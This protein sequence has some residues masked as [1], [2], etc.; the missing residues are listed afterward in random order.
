MGLS[1][2]D[3][4]QVDLGVLADAADDWKRTV[5][6]LKAL[7][8]QARKGLKAKADAARWAGVNASVSREFVGMTVKEI[9]DLYGEARGVHRALSDAH[10]DLS[11]CQTRMRAAVDEATRLGLIVAEGSGGRARCRF[12]AAPDAADAPGVAARPETSREAR[13]KALEAEIN[14]I[15]DVAAELDE[16]VAATLARIHGGDPHDADGR[17]VTVDQV[18]VERAA[19]LVAHARALAGRGETLSEARLRELDLI[20]EGNVGDAEFATGFYRS[21]GK[22]EAVLEFYG[23]MSLD[24]TEGH[25]AS[26]LALTRRLQEGMGLALAT[27]TDPDSRVRLPAGWGEEFR[28]LGTQPVAVNPLGPVQPLGYQVLGGLLRH[29]EYDPRFLLPI[30]E[31]VAQLHHRSP[32]LF[33]LATPGALGEDSDLGFNPGGGTGNGYDPLAS[34]LEGLGHSPEAAKQFFSDATPTV[35]RD[36]GSVE[37]TGKLGYSYFDELTRA[38]FDWP[39]ESSASPGSEKGIAAASHGPDALGHALEAAVT[40]APWDSAHGGLPRDPESVE[41]MRKVMDRYN[42]TRETP[43]PDAMM[44]SLGRMGAA[45]IDEFNYGSYGVGGGDHAN[46]EVIFA[47][48][49]RLG[50]EP[51]FGETDIANF[52]MLAGG[53]EE[54][55]GTLKS[56]QSL[57]VASGLAALENDHGRGS[58]FAQNTAELHGMLDES[59]AHAVRQEFRD[60]EDEKNLAG[61][62]AAEWRK[63]GVN[64]G[65]GVVVGAGVALIAGP[66]AGVVTAVA[67][68]IFVESV[69]STVNTAY[70]THTLEYL[71]ASEFNNDG[72]A[73]IEAGAVTE[74]GEKSAVR[75]T[76]RYAM[77]SGMGYEQVGQLNQ[78]VGRSYHQGRGTIKDRELAQ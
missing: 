29:G 64:A 73:I 63:N 22:P 17:Y 7:R 69:G 9:G 20:L 10:A 1:F 46:R 40:G 56:A 3:L 37:P 21:F 19:R 43:P 39:S 16:N 76:E 70:G 48:S 57:Y 2:S 49:S 71:E 45:Y 66:A 60:M 77:R 8:E 54:A 47:D 27:A 65:V 26:R 11:G 28:R 35:Y 62:Q 13:R 33:E 41:I 6:G 55:Y 67:V 68:P 53:H 25:D 42:V 30:A 4:Y 38:D 59:R 72:R 52:L 32:H 5:A 58:L 50:S 18:E 74:E 31:H 51:A 14:R 12:A 44:D 23:R 75:P 34:V 36:D 61:E 78:D 15:R 24:G